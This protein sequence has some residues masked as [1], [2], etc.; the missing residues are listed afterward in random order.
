MINQRV[1]NVVIVWKRESQNQRLIK[2]VSRFFILFLPLLSRIIPGFPDAVKI[3][4]RRP[5][6]IPLNKEPGN[7]PFRARKVQT[8]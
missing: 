1:Y 5:H 2:G 8:R 4:N 6:D 3:S 7:G